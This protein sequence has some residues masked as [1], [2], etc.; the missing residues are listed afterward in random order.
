MS[1]KKKAPVDPVIGSS[2][3]K[4]ASKKDAPKTPKKKEEPKK[5]L[6][7]ERPIVKFV[8]DSHYSMRRI[9]DTI[10]IYSKED[11]SNDPDARMARIDDSLAEAYEQHRFRDSDNAAIK[12]A[13]TAIE[14]QTAQL[15]LDIEYENICCDECAAEK[16]RNIADSLRQLRAF[17][18]QQNRIWQQADCLDQIPDVLPDNPEQYNLINGKFEKKL[19]VRSIEI[20]DD[21]R[22]RIEKALSD[23]TGEEI[24]GQNSKMLKCKLSK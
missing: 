7:D 8:F 2:K 23:I 22:K 14:E 12:D 5:F 17:K 13:Y 24:N 1:T 19:D 16:L 11:L 6:V 18:G 3:K 21:Q 4:E 10:K 9:T 20:T 15:A